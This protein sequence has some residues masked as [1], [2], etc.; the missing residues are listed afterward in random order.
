[1]TDIF[2]HIHKSGGTT[3]MHLLN[4]HYEKE[5]IFSIDGTRYKSSMDEFLSNKSDNKYDLIKGHQF[6][7]VHKFLSNEARYFA[8]LRD[9]FERILSLYNFL[10]Q[11]NLYPEINKNNLTITE[12]VKSGLA[13]AA[14]NGMVRFIS[15][16]DRDEASY[17]KITDL[18][19]KKA[20]EN[21]EEKFCFV[22]LSEYFDLSLLS[23]A[24][25]LKWVNTP[26]YK[27]K[28]ITNASF[29]NSSLTV[30]D[31][32]FLTDYLKFDICLY[33]YIKSQFFYSV[34]NAIGKNY[35][36]LERKFKED[37]QRFNRRRDQ[38]NS[39]LQK[40]VMRIKSV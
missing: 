19:L 6:Y 11:I 1:M 20:I 39:V 25:W 18:H 8:I 32:L 5:K 38:S 26:L 7:G 14:D 33:N 40:I 34:K 27:S 9:P 22:G 23:V 24:S 29:K 31:Y 21:I 17:G 36:S 12:F 4:D 28:N 13:L 10:R 15:G 37:N 35:L 2:I 16:V 3:M 30:D